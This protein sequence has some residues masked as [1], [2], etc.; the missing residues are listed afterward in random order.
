ME[1]GERVKLLSDG[2]FKYLFGYVKNIRFT[3]YLLECLFN[4]KIGSLKEKVIINNSLI[5]NKDYYKEHGLEIDVRLTIKDFNG[6][7]ILVNLE[8]YTSYTI[9]SILKSF[10]YLAKQYVNQFETGSDFSRAKM[11]YQFNLILGAYKEDKHYSMISQ[12][13]KKELFEKLDKM[14]SNKLNRKHIFEYLEIYLSNKKK[15]DG[16][17]ENAKRLYAFLGT[18]SL[19][20]AEEFAK[21]DGELMQIMKEAK[22]FVDTN[23]FSWIDDKYRKSLIKEQEEAAISKGKSLGIAEGKSL[24]IAEGK[25]IGIA[26]GI[27]K[28]IVN[29]AK[30]MLKNNFSKN[31]IIEVTGLSKEEL[32]KLK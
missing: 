12:K 30:N 14:I 3:E 8:P 28:G 2:M 19:E 5:L 16:Y 11:L 18:N 24:G 20:E 6:E 22:K 1:K 7:D 9:R 27:T 13:E 17:T 31:Q 32:D 25:S 23:D 4:L 15:Y 26:E 21:G 29:V 10:A